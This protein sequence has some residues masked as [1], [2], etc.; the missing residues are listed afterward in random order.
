MAVYDPPHDAKLQGFLRVLVK[1][2]LPV[3]KDMIESVR[4][5]KVYEERPNE[6]KMVSFTSA[7][8]K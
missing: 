5:V 6:W 3:P 8:W 7:R 1:N 4:M 2:K